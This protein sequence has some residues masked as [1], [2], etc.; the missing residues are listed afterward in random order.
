MKQLTQ[1]KSGA[2]VSLPVDRSV[3]ESRLAFTWATQAFKGVGF[4]R[5]RLFT[6][7]HAPADHKMI[8]SVCHRTP[9]AASMAGSMRP[10]IL[11]PFRSPHEAT[12][13]C[14]QAVAFRPEP[15]SAVRVRAEVSCMYKRLNLPK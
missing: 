14:L 9:C 10:R 12:T 8:G 15:R 7:V 1:G 4:A 3:A 13:L 5:P 6:V 2:C 11:R